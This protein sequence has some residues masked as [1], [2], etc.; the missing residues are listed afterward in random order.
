MVWSQVQL[1]HAA[2]FKASLVDWRTLDGHF[3]E[4]HRQYI[5]IDEDLALVEESCGCG[6]TEEHAEA[7]RGSAN[8]SL[9][10]LQR[11]LLED[12]RTLKELAKRVRFLVAEVEGN[13]SV[14]EASLPP[15][16]P[17]LAMY[18]L[19]MLLKQA[20]PYPEAFLH[21]EAAYK[22]EH[23]IL[24]WAQ[25]YMNIRLWALAV[26]SEYGLLLHPSSAACCTASRLASFRLCLQH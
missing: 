12:A 15:V 14:G 3:A 13:G 11:A 18:P 5:E 22:A 8:A 24:S 17:P 10:R 26:A 19:F 6:L 25:L 23:G 7:A 9:S 4:A 20:S 16:C 1:R 21:N 2:R